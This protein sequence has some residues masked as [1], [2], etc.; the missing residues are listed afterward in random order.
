MN[1]FAT[2]REDSPFF[3]IFDHGCVPILNLLGPS[4]VTL[5]GSDETEAYM[6]DWSRCT[7]TQRALIG[8]VVVE[9]RGG[10][11]REFV[12]YMSEGGMMP[13]RVSQTTSAS[14]LA[15]TRMML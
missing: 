9:L 1:N 14:F 3:T 15:E 12:N 5:E 10:S 13:I 11:F 6:L 2:L 7:N 8:R 4:E